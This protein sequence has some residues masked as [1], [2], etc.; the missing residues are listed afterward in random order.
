MKWVTSSWAYSTII[1]LTDEKYI[2][3]NS[4]VQQ[5]QR[6]CV[7]RKKIVVYFLSPA[8]PLLNAP[9]WGKGREKKIH[10]SSLLHRFAKCLAS[11]RAGYMAASSFLSECF[12]HGR[13]FSCVLTI[14]SAETEG[15]L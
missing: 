11:C 12:H 8:P 10:F 2:K 15:C 7:Y 6:I 13:I 9:D 1:H 14:M 3:N 5:G 4:R